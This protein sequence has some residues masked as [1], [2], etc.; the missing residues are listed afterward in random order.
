MTLLTTTIGSYPKPDFV[1]VRDWVHP[2]SKYKPTYDAH[3]ADERY[4]QDKEVSTSVFLGTI[5]AV[6]A[7]VGVGIDVPTD[8]EQGREHYVFY[9]LRHLK[10][11]NFNR[12]QRRTIRGVGDWCKDVPTISGKIEPLDRFLRYDWQIAQSVAGDN[13][14]I[15]IT[16]PGPMTIADTVV[17]EYYGDKAK[18]NRALAEALNAEIRDLAD[19]GCKWIQVDEPL[20]ARYPEE[21]LAYG[22]ENLER[23][24]AGVQ[25][26]I[27]RV[28]HLCCGYPREVDDPNPPK[29]DPSSYFKL[30]DALD[31]ANVDAVS[32]EDAHRHNDL[33]LL[34]RFTNTRVIL[35]VVAIAQTRV[36]SVD[37]LRSRLTA[38]LQHIDA[39][40]L[41]V[42]PD[43]GLGMLDK[44]TAYKK[45]EN[46]IE[47][48]RTRYT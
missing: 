44:E 48:A 25:D 31:D 27:N 1:K 41:I 3:A 9:Q 40:R 28:V 5:D 13:H 14:S 26:E 39:A 33:A 47:A 6:R 8:G 20:F 29:A 38:A 21:A 45:L 2:K 34:E 16:L 19:A 15:K 23:C 37:E 46:L 11:V 42:A 7:Q 32:I 18:L 36:E 30:A 43:C 12:L 35:G 17:D 24:F 22:I 10:G 4:F